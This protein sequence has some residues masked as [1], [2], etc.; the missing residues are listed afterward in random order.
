MLFKKTVRDENRRDA[1]RT[2]R[3]DLPPFASRMMRL[4][5]LI[6]PW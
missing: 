1:N 6:P 5:L 4:K 3:P 2:R